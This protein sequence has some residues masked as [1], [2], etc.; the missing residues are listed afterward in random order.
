MKRI[1]DNLIKE[2]FYSYR[3]IFLLSG[4]R[5]VGKTTTAKTA[6]PYI[7]ISTGTTKK[8]EKKYFQAME[9]SSI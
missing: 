7:Y 9:I 5:Q 2:H 6:I 4:P 3:Q 8:I 1:Y